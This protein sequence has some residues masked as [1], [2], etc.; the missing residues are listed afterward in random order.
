[1]IRKINLAKEANQIVE[2]LSS[3]FQYPNHPEWSADKESIQVIQQRARAYRRMAPILN[4]FPSYKNRIQGLAYD[5][6]GETVGFS[7]FYE[8][9]PTI[10]YI[11]YIGVLANYRKKG[12]GKAL[13]AA[14]LE[15][16]REFAGSYVSLAVS[17]G[18]LPAENLYSQFGFSPITERIALEMQGGKSISPVEA[19]NDFETQVT[20]Q[21]EWEAQYAVA[22]AAIPDVIKSKHPITPDSYKPGRLAFISRAFNF[23]AGRKFK[24]ITLQKDASLV[25]WSFLNMSRNGRVLNAIE[26]MTIDDDHV[27]EYLLTHSLNIIT[28]ANTAPISLR[29]D[30][31]QDA[32]VQAA[33]P[34][35][36]LKSI[37]TTLGLTL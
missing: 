4:L 1:M 8:T 5:V 21:R 37:D 24:F 20:S 28:Q 12:I 35:F 7:L 34:L 19:D 17:K 31:W 9:S 32:L 16:I 29:L 25:G 6:E 3:V 11:D 14:T 30:S 22:D 15:R 18:N 27:A 23:L 26:I 33:T 10:W 2:L 36:T 13:V